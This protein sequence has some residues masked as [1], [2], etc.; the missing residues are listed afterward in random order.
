[1][2]GAGSRSRVDSGPWREAAA[3]L[4]TKSHC[5]LQLQQGMEEAGWGYGREHWFIQGLDAVKGDAESH[6]R[7]SDCTGWEVRGERVASQ[8]RFDFSHLVTSLS[9]P[10]LLCPLV[11]LSLLRYS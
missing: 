2:S 8:Q 6:S 9:H 10:V 7:R 11:P 4:P 3:G 1:M 5:A